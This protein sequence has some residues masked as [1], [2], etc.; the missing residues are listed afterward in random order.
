MVTIA[1]DQ[2]SVLNM[3]HD[4]TSGLNLETKAYK[5]KALRT[6]PEH[7]DEEKVIDTLVKNALE[8]IDEAQPNWTYVA[9]RIYL[10]GLYQ[11]ESRS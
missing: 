8:N 4:A 5:E 3:I 9:S 6:I 1:T 7:A 11:K 2:H 10:Y